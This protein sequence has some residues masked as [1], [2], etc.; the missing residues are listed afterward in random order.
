MLKH[1]ATPSRNM[2]NQ[3]THRPCT[4]RSIYD[5]S[6]FVAACSR[7]AMGTPPATPREQEA[8]AAR[9]PAAPLLLL[10]A[11]RHRS[12][13]PSRRLPAPTRSQRLAQPLARPQ[14][15]PQPLM[16][17]AFRTAPSLRW[18]QAMW[19]QSSLLALGPRVRDA[20]Q[21][22]KA[23]CS[24]ATESISP[25]APSPRANKST[26]P[27]CQRASIT[28][29]VPR[30]PAQAT[31]YPVHVQHVRTC[32]KLCTV[33][34]ACGIPSVSMSAYMFSGVQHA[35]APDAADPR[36]AGS[37][38]R[39]GP[40][41]AG[42]LR[43]FLLQPW[44]IAGPQHRPPLA[45]RAAPWRGSMRAEAAPTARASLQHQHPWRQVV[46]YSASA[47]RHHACMHAY[48]SSLHMHRAGLSAIRSAIT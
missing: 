35:S 7:R 41:P 43:S 28:Y 39:S 4:R 3:P 19:Q 16:R 40:R 48:A 8:A 38:H 1:R 42:T 34:A 47:I 46:K 6:Q 26:A 24:S 29:S 15:C 32:T 21:A 44:Q 13:R 27:S 33:H 23:P 10:L 22:A 20:H 14:S 25:S 36:R 18:R 30:R 5:S 9:H 37:C 12:L 31:S 45:A 11:L 2:F 17:H